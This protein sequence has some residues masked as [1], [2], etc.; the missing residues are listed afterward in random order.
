[1]NENLLTIE[2]K[3]GKTLIHKIDFVINNCI[4]DFA[5]PKIFIHL[6]LY[7]NMKLNLQKLVL[8]K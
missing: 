1:M 7:V 8:M 4:T 6:I 2:Y 3:Y 5:I